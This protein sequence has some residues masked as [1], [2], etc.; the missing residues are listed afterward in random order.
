MLT[1]TPEPGSAAAPALASTPAPVPAPAPALA[2]W[3]Q[4]FTQIVMPQVSGEFATPDLAWP[5]ATAHRTL[6][7][8]EYPGPNDSEDFYINQI[9]PPPPGGVVIKPFQMPAP[10]Q[11]E[12]PDIIVPLNGK[13]AVVEDWT[14]QNYTNELHAF[15]IHQT[16]FRQLLGGVL[17]G[18]ML[19]TINIPA[20][21]PVLQN[22]TVIPAQPGEVTLRIVFTRDIAGTFVFHCHILEHEDGGMMGEIRVVP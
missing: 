7:F 14:I 2:Q 17:M 4:R 15:H 20:A 21:R 8:T 16:H 5:A 22:G 6:A 13:A 12:N 3:I 19:D 10:N 1:A 9:D 11:R 18:P